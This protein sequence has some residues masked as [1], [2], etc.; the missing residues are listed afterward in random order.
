M[1][2]ICSRSLDGSDVNIRIKKLA[3]TLTWTQLYMYHNIM[4]QLRYVPEC[5][6]TN[7]LYNG[8]SWLMISEHD[9]VH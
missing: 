6:I 4:Y 2:G 5:A 1:I 8:A 3:F 7:I 9:S